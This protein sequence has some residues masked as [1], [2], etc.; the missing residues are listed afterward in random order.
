MI[1]HGICLSLSD[2]ISMILSSYINVAAA[3]AAAELLQ[4][5]MALF[6]S[7]LKWLCRISVELFKL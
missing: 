5:Q 6:C 1:S 4:S 2:S 3:A 7:F